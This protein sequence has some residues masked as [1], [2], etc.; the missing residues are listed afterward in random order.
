MADL[1]SDAD[2]VVVGAGPA[3][4]AAAVTAAEAHARVL[5]VDEGL[6]AGGQIW[7]HTDPAKLPRTAKSW[8][9]RLA[10]S[11]VRVEV[12]TSVVDMV[13]GF[14][15]TTESADGPGVI[16]AR[17]VILATG[18]RERFLPFPGW[19]LPGVVG[20]GGAQALLKSGTDLRGQRA[21]IAGTGPLL[22]A[23]AGAL[24]RAGV[25]VVRVAE[26]ARA[27]EVYRFGASLWRTPGRLVQAAYERFGAGAARY[28][29]G[30]WVESAAGTDRVREVTLTDG[31][32][33]RTEAC[34][35]LCVGF[36]LVPA[37]ELARLLGC[38]VQES[39]VQV[40]AYQR[41]SV[42][43]VFCAGEPTGVAGVDASIVEGRIAALVATDRAAQAEPLLAERDAHRRFAER[44]DTT[45]A[46]RQELR[47]L[48]RADTIVC[49]CED[50]RYEQLT[51]FWN[52]R[53]AK[54][55]TRAGMGPC[56][57]RVCGAALGFLMGYEADTVRPPIAPARVRTL[58]ETSHSAESIRGDQ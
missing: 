36:G 19:T 20:A 3:G 35:L 57:G 41:T 18:A 15:L 27:R 17:R 22:V 45:F 37:T 51:S 50:V 2:V 47:G 29:L 21:I 48:P 52:A 10:R 4:I 25:R 6:R 39:R 5:L 53:E 16:A 11:A 14:M 42:P 1:R 30:T 38:A 28:D 33:S 56:Q 9:N 26:Q 31:R 34:E 54:L 46:L 43:D 58:L 8:L 12:G 40:D 23:V 7:R 49:R 32:R 24:G 13:S 55:R 44:M